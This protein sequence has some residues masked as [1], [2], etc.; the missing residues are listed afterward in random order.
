MGPQTFLKINV[1]YE[2]LSSSKTKP[3]EVAGVSRHLKIGGRSE[4]SSFS[5]IFD[6]TGYVAC[7]VEKRI[8]ALDCIKLG[9]I[10]PHSTVKC[11]QY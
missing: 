10:F 9:F 6:L 5:Y 4:H 3:N 7:I 11:A 8:K 1:L 2:V